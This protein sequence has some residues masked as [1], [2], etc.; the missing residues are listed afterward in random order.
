MTTEDAMRIVGEVGPELAV[1][2]HFGMK[3]IFAGPS[4]EAERIERE[5]S[6]RTIAAKDGMRVWVGEEV[7]VGMGK[8]KQKGLDA[9]A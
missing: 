8:R 2:T 3:M 6:I 5:S 4:K 7:E 9:F 1:V